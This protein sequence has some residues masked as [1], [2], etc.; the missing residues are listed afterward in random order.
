M[1]DYTDR[2]RLFG[3]YQAVYDLG[4]G[5]Y[6]GILHVDELVIWL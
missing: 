1:V 5:A 3:Y 6:L 2:E 4:H